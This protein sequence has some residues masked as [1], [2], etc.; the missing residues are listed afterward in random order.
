MIGALLVYDSNV[1][2]QIVNTLIK[3]LSHCGYSVLTINVEEN[4][5]LIAVDKKYKTSKI[6]SSTLYEILEQHTIR[7]IIDFH[8]ALPYNYLNPQS[9]DVKHVIVFDNYSYDIWNSHLLKFISPASTSLFL[10]PDLDRFSV[11]CEIHNKQLLPPLSTIS[12]ENIEKVRDICIVCNA[13]D[14]LSEDDNYSQEMGTNT[15]HKTKQLVQQL[16][17]YNP[18]IICNDSFKRKAISDH[19][20]S[21]YLDY[22]NI[23]SISYKQKML[24][25]SK[26]TVLV[27]VKSPSITGSW[28]IADIIS[29]SSCLIINKNHEWM[30]Y[31]SQFLSADALDKISYENETE[32]P[33]K[34]KVL[35]NDDYLRN[36]ITSELNAIAN[37]QCKL[38]TTLKKT[39]IEAG[40][41]PNNAGT[42]F[43]LS[44]NKLSKKYLKTNKIK[45]GA[46][47]HT[48]YTNTYD[49]LYYECKKTDDIDW[50]FILVPFMQNNVVVSI[51]EL[52]QMMKDK[53]YPYILGY[54][55]TTDTY[56]DPATFDINVSITQTPYDGQR[57]SYYYGADYLS[58]FSKCFT[59]SYGCSLVDYDSPPFDSFLMFHQSKNCTTLS[60][61]TEFVKIL[62]THSKHS[63]I[64][65]GYIKCDKYL[66]YRNNSDFTIEK[67]ADYKTILF[68][69]PRWIGTI[70][71][72]NLLTYMDFFIEYLGKHQDCL[73]QIMIHDLLEDEVVSTR[74]IF[75]KKAFNKW[76]G[77]IHELKNIQIIDNKEFLDCVFN[78]DIFIGDYCSTIMEFTLTGK[79]VIYTPTDVKL[80]AYGKQIANSY[81]VVNSTYEMQKTLDKLIED[82]NDPLKHKRLDVI[83]LLSDRHDGQSI[84]QY[85][86][87]CFRLMDLPQ[88][89]ECKSVSSKRICPSTVVSVLVINHKNES[90]LVKTIDS[91]IKQT[92]MYIELIVVDDST[93]GVSTDTIEEW[94]NNHRGPNII[95]HKMIKNDEVI[96]RIRSLECAFAHSS[97][98]YITTIDAPDVFCSDS[99]LQDVFKEIDGFDDPPKVIIG[100][101]EYR[102]KKCS[103]C[104]EMIVNTPAIK[105]FEMFSLRLEVPPISFWSR[106]LYMK[107][108]AK[109]NHFILSGELA[110]FLRISRDG[111]QLHYVNSPLISLTKKVNTMGYD[112][113]SDRK[114]L[115]LDLINTYK[116]E[117]LPFL[118]SFD[119]KNIK[120]VLKQYKKMIK[121]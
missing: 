24:N 80:S 71:E 117:V 31:Y 13:S 40:T 120:Q 28:T 97:G 47:V 50:L 82:G 8:N 76:I 1:E 5:E 2:V 37:E 81:Y 118:A 14:H 102:G 75:T 63:S 20:L 115:N 55:K 52:E 89:I 73:L 95:R 34:I 56:I 87:Q 112:S 22:T 65:I 3:E 77:R 38:I 17:K 59:I 49:T 11:P 25:E 121:E 108:E 100:D 4:N 90:S 48:L 27:D 45:I 92:Y 101:A 70:G 12:S 26:I 57:V 33:K 6:C 19:T 74:R 114:Y 39:G 36:S 35:L 104:S 10:R 119:Q 9:E 44:G 96:G 116:R 107:Y 43:T 62:D 30:N 98:Q 51:E 72:S 58:T 41:N 23:D 29:S 109:S 88:T 42:Y 106:E 67:R 93:T 105:R 53:K 110:R 113:S 54:D 86:I 103:N 46:I 99:I 32:I 69:K 78:A 111:I 79:P 64:P 16:T 61:N 15:L 7:L 18:K 60:E 21:D 84:A 85:C 68:W 94:I 66:N 91:V 83:P